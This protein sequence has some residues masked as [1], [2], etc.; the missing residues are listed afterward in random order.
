MF[1]KGPSVCVRLCPCPCPCPCPCVCGRVDP[2]GHG[3]QDPDGHILLILFVIHF[4][5]YAC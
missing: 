1:H 3:H 5:I 2:D 4:L